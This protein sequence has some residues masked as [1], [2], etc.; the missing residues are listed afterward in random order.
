MTTFDLVIQLFYTFS[1]PCGHLETTL[2]Q[3]HQ[4]ARQRKRKLKS[5]PQHLASKDHLDETLCE[6]PPIRRTNFNHISCSPP[7]PALATST[8]DDNSRHKT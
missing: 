6:P 5:T 3:L 2:Q 8:R 7:A 4:A 1:L